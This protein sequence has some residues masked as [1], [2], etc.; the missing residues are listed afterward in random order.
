MCTL[1]FI[2]LFSSGEKLFNKK[3]YASLTDKHNVFRKLN[4]RF[5]TQIGWLRN[6][7]SPEED[8]NVSA[9]HALLLVI[10]TVVAR[11]ENSM[12]HPGECRI[13]KLS[14]I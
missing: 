2:E 12:M 11:F 6:D 8:L 10:R 4:I 7:V 3:H 5:Y 13:P 9:I 1:C 14:K